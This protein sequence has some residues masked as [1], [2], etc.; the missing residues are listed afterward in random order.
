MTGLDPNRY[1]TASAG[2]S[3]ARLF[4]SL[5]SLMSDAERFKDAHPF[6]VRCRSCQSQVAFD[7]ISKRDVSSSTL[8]FATTYA[9][10]RQSSLLQSSGPACPGCH[11]PLT[12]VSLRMQLE[13]QIREHIGKY[14]EGWTVCDDPTCGN[15]TRMMGVYGRR[16]LRPGC[17]GHVAFEVRLHFRGNSTGR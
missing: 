4:S 17:L 6:L 10:Y 7:P 16:C 1:R 8:Y 12:S 2:E 9:E 3:E 13:V 5:D 15:R 11:A 14:Y